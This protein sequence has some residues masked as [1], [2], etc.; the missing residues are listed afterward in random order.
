[1]INRSLLSPI[2]RMAFVLT[3][4]SSWGCFAQENSGAIDPQAKQGTDTSAPGSWNWAPERADIFWGV[5]HLDLQIQMA[6]K[7]QLAQRIYET[8]FWKKSSELLFKE[9]KD[10]KSDLATWKARLD[11][12]AAR[13]IRAFLY[14]VVSKDLFFYADENFS[15]T[16]RQFNAILP[17]IE[18]LSSRQVPS[19]DKADIVANWVDQLVPQLQFPTLLL[20][21]RYSNVDRALARVDEIEGAIRIGIGLI[22]D[23]GG[24]FKN[25]RRIE[26]KRGNRL[27]WRISAEMIPWDQIPET[28]V[29][30]RETIQD[31]R[32]AC[33]DKSLVLSLGTLDDYFCIVISGD[34][35]WTSRFGSD[36]HLI[37]LPGLKNLAKQYVQRGLATST[38][39]TSDEAVGALQE[40]MLDGFFRKIARTTLLPIIDEQPSDS[41]LAVWL[42]SAVDDASWLDEQIGK[43]VV[44]YKG[45]SRLAWISDRTW[46]SVQVD[47][48]PMHLMDSSR[49]LDGMR[50]VGPDPLLMLNMRLAPHPEYFNSARQIVRK[51]K[52][53][54]EELMQVNDP[55]TDL[56]PWKPIERQIKTL[57][58]LVVG[59]TQ[60][61]QNRILPNLNGE[62]LVVVH[63]GQLQ[64]RNWLPMLGPSQESL[65]LPEAALVSGLGDSEAFHAGTISIVNAVGSM[66]GNYGIYPPVAPSLAQSESWSLGVLPQPW[67]QAEV[68]TFQGIL[69]TSPRWNW[70]G[71][72]KDQWQTFTKEDQSPSNDAIKL[73]GFQ[74]ANGPLASA[75]LIDFGGIARLENRWLAF[76]LEK[77]PTDTEGH[78]AIP[79]TATGRRLTLTRAEVQTFL[80]CFE[81]LG[82]LTSFSS[83]DPQGFTLL[84][85]RYEWSATQSTI[86]TE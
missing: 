40:L 23:I 57:W 69:A 33:K 9:W 26:D 55:Q 39:H 63:S 3:W 72:S 19:E 42:T 49:R 67:G 64:S 30:D 29:L 81:Q 70:L 24:F 4:A 50:R 62:H 27:E 10:R 46:E 6:Q 54:F 2:L 20:A 56:G 48:T 17:A 13:E 12:P 43:H 34:Q 7:S 47:R 74:Q 78:L 60:E 37:D 76:L 51:L 59:I 66:L 25:L 79:P 35:E 52:G 85:A 77:A 5:H 53:S 61:W 86:P 18:R 15:K 45:A 75:A 65:P 8:S 31:L 73:L 11:N 83:S 14:D 41:D 28:D 22:P 32:M 21:G 38:Y 58:P 84:R 1:M 44:R 68:G 82:K 71:Y 36:S 16:I 80:D